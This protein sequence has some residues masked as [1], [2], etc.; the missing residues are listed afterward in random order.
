M[1]TEKFLGMTREQRMFILYLSRRKREQPLLSYRFLERATGISHSMLEKLFVHGIYKGIA[2]DKMCKLLAL[3]G[4]SPS[5]A[6][7][8]LGIVPV[9]EEKKERE[10]AET[11]MKL[12]LLQTQDRLPIVRLID[13]QLNL[14]EREQ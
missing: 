11:A 6:S 2:F 1:S 8:V 3:L 13:Y 9:V 7:H 14:K 4:I 10:I 12:Y 5:T